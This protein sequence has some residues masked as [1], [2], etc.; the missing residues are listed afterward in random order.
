MATR[1]SE[2]GQATRKQG[3]GLAVATLGFGIAG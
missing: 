3:N 1:P 2:G